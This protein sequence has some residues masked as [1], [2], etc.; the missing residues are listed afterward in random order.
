M[1]SIIGAIVNSTDSTVT[2]FGY[3]VYQGDEIPPPEIIGPFGS[4]PRPNPKMLMDNGETVW[5][6][7]CYWGPEESV[8]KWIGDRTVTIITGAQYRSQRAASN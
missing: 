3:G 4:I 2:M 5:G 1:S 7:E 6:C 8:K